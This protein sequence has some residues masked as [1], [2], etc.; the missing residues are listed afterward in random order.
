M[1]RAAKFA[2]KPQ[3]GSR[4]ISGRRWALVAPSSG[5]RQKVPSD[6]G[7]LSPGNW[8]H[9]SS[10]DDWKS[11]LQKKS[12]RSEGRR[13]VWNWFKISWQLCFAPFRFL[14]RPFWWRVGG[15]FHHWKPKGSVDA[16]KHSVNHEPATPK[17]AIAKRVPGDQTHEEETVQNE[18][19]DGHTADRTNM[20]P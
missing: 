17:D 13:L 20:M 18:N 9:L 6:K 8:F 4:T 11:W 3:T 12:E 16:L 19:L 1:D 5:D 2:A 15:I 10:D 7:F 14:L